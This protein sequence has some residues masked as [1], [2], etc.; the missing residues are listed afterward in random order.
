MTVMATTSILFVLATTL[1]MMVAYQTQTTTQRTT[2]LRATHVADAGINAYLFDLKNDYGY[3]REAP[4][5]G[6]ITIGDNERYR[7]TA[8][9]ATSGHPLTLRSTGIAGDGTVTIAATVRFPSYAD[10]MFLTNADLNVAGDAIIN[11]QVRSNGSIVNQGKIVGKAT[12]G[13]TVTGNGSFDRGYAENQPI[14]D[15]NQVLAAMDDMM[16][17]AR[18]SSSY[19][20]ATGAF[21]YKVTVSGNMIT[22]EKVLGGTTTGNFQTTVVTVF[23]VPASGVVYFADNVWISG[24]YSVP[25]TIVSS[26]EMY[27]IDDYGPTDANATATSGLLAKGNIIVPAW[28]TSV[29]TYLTINAALLSQSGRIYADVKQGVIRERINISGALT[30]FDSGG[31]WGSYDKFTGQPVAGFRQNVY[32]YDQRLSQY[33]PPM[34][35]TVLDGSLK[36]DTWLED[37]TQQF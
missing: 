10:Y 3:Y 18:A 11:G 7:V 34:Y 30:A 6:W 12:A 9:P 4:D 16:V 26:S 28:Y 36:V 15:F 27:L 1:M 37:A 23:A 25:L 2:R 20:P 19:F 35:P 21:G 31:T 29:K 13:G 5:T 17:E 32:T 24:D 33:P 22:V 8:E 14:V